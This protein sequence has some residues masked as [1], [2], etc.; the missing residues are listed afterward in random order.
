[1]FNSTDGEKSPVELIG[2]QAMIENAVVFSIFGVLVILYGGVVYDLA[3]QLPD[4]Y[5]GFIQGIYSIHTFSIL[6]LSGFIIIA[7]AKALKGDRYVKSS[8]LIKGGLLFA[9]AG[10]S[11]GAIVAGAFFGIGF[12]L[13]F[14]SLLNTEEEL[15]TYAIRFIGLSGDFLILLSTIVIAYLYLLNSRKEKLRQLGITTL[16]HA[17]IIVSIYSNI[18]LRS[19]MVSIGMIYSVFLLYALLDK[20]RYIRSSE[21][22][23]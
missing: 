4:K 1:M 22:P 9:R 16:I 10:L 11:A 8:S 20:V 19:D 23:D 13:W 15:V 18:D 7:I 5:V 3:D 12:G 14:I 21:A 17:L 6:S 2:L